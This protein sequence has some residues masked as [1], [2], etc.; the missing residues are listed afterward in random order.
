MTEGI[1]YVGSDSRRSSS[2]DSFLFVRYSK[3][4][5]RCAITD[6]NGLWAL[7]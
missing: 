4:S 7:A 6:E 1:Y 3:I 2:C 5:G